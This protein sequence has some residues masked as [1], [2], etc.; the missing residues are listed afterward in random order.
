MELRPSALKASLLRLWREN[1]AFVVRRIR[2]AA[3]E[4]GVISF[5]IPCNF[6]VPD[7]TNFTMISA[8]EGQD[9]LETIPILPGEQLCARHDCGRGRTSRIPHRRYHR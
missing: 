9:F 6:K 3:K 5:R 1:S 2:S 7:I 8:K 4:P